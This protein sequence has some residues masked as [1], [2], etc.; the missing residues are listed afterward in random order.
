MS[1]YHLVRYRSRTSGRYVY[2]GATC[3]FW[4]C[5]LHDSDTHAGMCFS[6]EA[7]L[8]E[9]LRHAHTCPNAN[10]NPAAT[11]PTN[12]TQGEAP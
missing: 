11:R 6:Q 8:E 5:D 4:Q 3:W 7:A 2:R 9:V 12:H 1:T 10:H